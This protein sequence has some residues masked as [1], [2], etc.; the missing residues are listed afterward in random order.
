MSMPNQSSRQV[1]SEEVTGSR[2]IFT[3]IE[4]L[5]VIAI[6]AIL[7]AM[8]LPALNKARDKARS[9]QCLNQEKQVGLAIASYQGDYDDYYPFMIS[10]T[11]I[12]FERISVW[13]QG[14]KSTYLGYISNP[15]IFDCPA[16]TTREVG[17][18]YAQNMFSG[19]GNDRFINVSYV[20]NT[21]QCESPASEPPQARKFT[22]FKKLSMSIMFMEVDRAPDGTSGDVNNH[23][24]SHHYA[25]QTKYFQGSVPHHG[26][27]SNY[28]FMD[29]HAASYTHG[30]WYN[31]LRR[32]G[33][34][35][36]IGVNVSYLN[37]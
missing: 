12:C 33:D 6:I 14:G 21:F 9:T 34:K 13:L 7:A 32:N 19:A 37:Q 4:L 3:L 36:P 28:L 15:R 35:A 11:S 23:M 2:K 10:G 5:V 25:R 26:S 22:F 29:G 20:L 30:Q 18:D 31:D 1:E 27:M 24:S 16:D 8:L 17:V